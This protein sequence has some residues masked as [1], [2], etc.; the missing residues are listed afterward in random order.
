MILI[1]RVL[2]KIEKG[3]G[4]TLTISR[5]ILKPYKYGK[6]KYHINDNYFDYINTQ[7][8]AYMLGFFYADG[9]LVK[10]KSGTKRIGMDLIDKDIL[11]LIAKAM[12]FE[13]EIVKYKESK[14][15]FSSNV[16]IRYRFIATSPHLYDTLIK[17]GCVENKTSCL[18]FPS[19]DIVPKKY[20]DSFILGY[21]DGNGTILYT[22]RKN[23]NRREWEIG[24]CGTTE[25]IMGI[26]HYLNQDHLKLQRRWKERDNNNCSL[27]ISSNLKCYNILKQLYANSPIF[28]NRKHEKF[29]K[30][31]NQLF[32]VE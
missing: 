2:S 10:A 25:M 27:R 32:T 19:A 17:L 7:E 22:D 21:F 24:F 5:N 13:G 3:D 26:Q 1:I 16:G 20:L 23:K 6:R 8:K 31:E 9:Y 12:E 14:T 4:K 28:L 29:L 30:L 11:Q 18:K 15:S